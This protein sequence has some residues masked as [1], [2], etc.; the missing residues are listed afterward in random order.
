MADQE[1]QETNELRGATERMTKTAETVG[2][3]G[4]VGIEPLDEGQLKALLLGTDEAGGAGRQELAAGSEDLLD[5]PDAPRVRAYQ[6][7][8]RIVAL[9]QLLHDTR[10]TYRTMHLLRRPGEEETQEMKLL[11]EQFGRLYHQRQIE[12]REHPDCA[13]YLD[14]VRQLNEARLARVPNGSVSAADAAGTARPNR[15]L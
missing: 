13:A 2:A 8:Q 5:L 14:E 10:D 11:R 3:V 4:A 6:A 1:M 7:A 12:L 9:E 15:V